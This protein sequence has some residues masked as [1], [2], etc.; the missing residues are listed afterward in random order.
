[1]TSPTQP[2]LNTEWRYPKPDS[3]S[4]TPSAV[5]VGPNPLGRCRRPQPPRPLPSAS[6]ENDPSARPDGRIN[7]RHRA[8]A[9]AVEWRQHEHAGISRDLDRQLGAL[10]ERVDRLDDDGQRFGANDYDSIY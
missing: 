2:T 10:A 6:S 9:H 7:T 4:L 1:M 3:T 8:I 5:A